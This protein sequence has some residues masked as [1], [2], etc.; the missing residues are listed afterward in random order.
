MDGRW[1]PEIE[2]G[3]LTRWCP[4]ELVDKVIDECGRREKR[5]RLLP[6]RTMVYFELARCLYPRQGYEQV[7]EH[8]LPDDLDDLPAKTNKV[9]NKSS[10]CR[11]R[12]KV[13]AAVLEALFRR[14]A[15]PVA[16]PDSCPSA[17]W[18]GLRLEAFDGTTLDVADTPDNA[19][20]FVQP[21]GSCGPG[22][23]PQARL[24]TL[25]ECGTHAI[26][27]AAIGGHGQGETTLAMDIAAAAGPDTLVLADRGML[28][29]ALW[30]AFR[31]GGAHLLWRVKK[32]IA[33][34]PHT[35]LDDGTYLARVR[36]DKHKAAAL[37]REGKT[38]PS[39]ITVRVVEYTLDGHDE[40]YRLAASLLD[41]ATAPAAELATLYHERWEN[42]GLIGEIK[43]SQRGSHTVLA[44]AT[45][46]GV[47]QEIWAHLTVHHLTRDLIW[48]AA[49]SASPPLDPERISFRQAQHLIR[50]SLAADLSPL[51]A[52]AAP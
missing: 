42:E 37:R 10:L 43:T 39:A 33:V 17:F 30:T 12:P 40:V 24:V 5:R 13:G 29:V 31:D 23:Y 35:E 36:L 21:A 6:A 44:S 47:R 27:D 9:P 41:P 16:E 18:R 49:V 51:A 38:V 46:D 45:P 34:R 15:G 48:H 8:L 3:L 20:H 2:F 25:I 22:G 50:R 52:A 26:V 11:A 14:V 28:G 1:L 19:E 4:P 7:F 32:D